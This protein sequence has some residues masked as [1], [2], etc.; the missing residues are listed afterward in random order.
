M[1]TET[2][3]MFANVGWCYEDVRF[4]NPNISK[5]DAEQF[6]EKWENWIKENIVEFGMDMLQT[7]M[8]SQSLYKIEE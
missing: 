6:L 3:K 7:L 5:E 2:P 8:I 1:E 4:H